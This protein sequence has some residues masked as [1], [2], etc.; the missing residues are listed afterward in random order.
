MPELP[1]VERV[2]R[3]L[4]ATVVGRTVA[5]LRVRRRDVV[6]GSA[7]PKSLLAGRRIQRIYRHGKQLCL[8]GDDDQHCVCIHLGMSGSLRYLNGAANG[9]VLDNHCHVT[10][11]FAHGG[12]LV[13]R[14][15]RRFGGLW[16]F[17]QPQDLWQQRWKTLG[18]DAMTITAS[19]LYDKLVRTDRALKAAL[20]DQ[21][22]VAGL[23]N[24]YVD[25]LLFGCRLRPLKPASKLTK[26]QTRQMVRH[27]RRMLEKA[28]VAGGSTLRDYVDA[29]GRQGG[30]QS[31][32][33]VYGRG[34][35]SCKKCRRK[36]ATCKLAGRTTV[37][38]LRCQV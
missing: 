32:H 13:F 38:C 6:H 33:R 17:D 4:Q 25:E 8:V 19:Q 10:W 7:G 29:N 26:P 22:V 36:L 20:L 11:R 2:R 14:D 37:F 23:G 30:Y 34:G 3:T 12:Q 18:P 15:P 27:M 9:Q 31:L 28:V 35:K 1:E 21:H 16:T 24:I 5:S